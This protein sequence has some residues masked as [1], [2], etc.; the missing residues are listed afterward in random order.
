MGVKVLILNCTLRKSPQVSTRD[1]LVMRVENLYKK[2]NIK[3]EI[4]RPIDYFDNF[5]E[6][7]MKIKS[8]SILIIAS[9]IYGEGQFFVA[10]MLF[11]KL[12]EFSRS[13][14]TLKDQYPLYHKIGGVILT[15]NKEGFQEVAKDILF[16]LM[17]LG[18][19]IPRYSDI[20]WV[21]ENPAG[22]NYIEGGGDKNEYNEKRMKYL[23]QNTLYT[24]DLLDEYPVSPG[25]ISFNEL[26]ERDSYLP[27]RR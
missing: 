26:P 18:A 5:D 9:P 14:P 19:I 6:L 10:K 12:R 25:A 22:V 2:L 17:K 7:L 13:G 11:Q 20:Y 15:G 21:G 1:H 3:T 24:A 8:C 16:N 4:L 23:V 27:E